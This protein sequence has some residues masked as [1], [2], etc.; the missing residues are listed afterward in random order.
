MTITLDQPSLNLLGALHLG[1]HA[2]L[3]DRDD[4]SLWEVK[5]RIVAQ[6]T[7]YVGMATKRP[8]R[9]ADVTYGGHERADMATS[10]RVDTWGG[11]EREHELR[12]GLRLIRA[13]LAVRNGHALKL[14]ALGHGVGQVRHGPGVA[15][16]YTTEPLVPEASAPP[17]FDIVDD[18]GAVEPY[19]R[20]AADTELRI[21]RDGRYGQMI[22]SVT[23]G[24]SKLSTHQAFGTAR[25]MIAMLGDAGKSATAVQADFGKNLI[26]TIHDKERPVSLRIEDEWSYADVP[27][28]APLH[29]LLREYIRENVKADGAVV[30]MRPVDIAWHSFDATS[31]QIVT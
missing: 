26:V 16:G 11:P 6:V 8:P 14:T 5:H 7:S 30:V 1:C 2:R 18:A 15:F 13:G 10:V 21:D 29:R 20:I 19:P 4:G 25:T 27:L 17:A 31:D 9:P 28:P 24:T 12:D 23:S 22:L 3:E